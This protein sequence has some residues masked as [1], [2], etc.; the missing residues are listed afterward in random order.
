MDI[1]LPSSISQHSLPP[2]PYHKAIATP[3]FFDPHM[4][5]SPIVNRQSREIKEKRA[6]AYAQLG[7]TNFGHITLHNKFIKEKQF[8]SQYPTLKQVGGYRDILEHAPLSVTN[9]ISA[10][11]D[12]ATLDWVICPNNILILVKKTH[13][14]F[15]SEDVIGPIYDIDPISCIATL[16]KNK[17]GRAPAHDVSPCIVSYTNADDNKNSAGYPPVVKITRD[18]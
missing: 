12:H 11:P 16:R 10:G 13:I 8:Y 3:L 6:I 2:I 9:S 1:K 4:N 15:N 17:T 18:S 5:L 14:L 7:L